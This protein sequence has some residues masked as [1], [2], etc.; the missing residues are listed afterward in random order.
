MLKILLSITILISISWGDNRYRPTRDFGFSPSNH[1]ANILASELKIHITDNYLEVEEEVVLE[2]TMSSSFEGDDYSVELF[3]DFQLPKGSIIRSSILWFG[4]DILKGKL[5]DMRVARELYEDVVQRDEVIIVPRDPSLI[6][7]SSINS[8]SYNYSI[9]PVELGGTRRMRIRYDVPIQ[10]SDTLKVAEFASIFNHRQS[11]DLGVNLNISSEITQPIKLKTSNQIFTVTPDS[12]YIIERSNLIWW[13]GSARFLIEDTISQ[14]MRTHHVIKGPL[15]GYYH[16]VVIPVSDSLKTLIDSN[17]VNVTCQLKVMNS[18]ATQIV[19]VDKYYLEHNKTLRLFIRTESEWEGSFEWTVFDEVG[20]LKGSVDVELDSNE[21]S[22][23]SVVHMWANH[24]EQKLGHIL[25]YVDEN[26]SLLALEKDT[27]PDS[28]TQQYWDE[29]VPLLKSYEIYSSIDEIVDFGKVNVVVMD[30][31]VLID[32]V[33]NV[34]LIG[35]PIEQFLQWELQ[36]NTL[37]VTLNGE[38]LIGSKVA[39]Y[40]LQGQLLKAESL[41]AGGNQFQLPQLSRPQYIVVIEHSQK[42]YTVSF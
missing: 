4:E 27:L 38:F 35:S 33:G 14:S 30:S 21:V 9:Y 39:A 29:G 6:E 1:P 8:N 16:E 12:D 24:Q 2:A 15:E 26:M 34:G 42:R 5:M 3:G 11:K 10:K 32:D 28:L 7:R 41:K 20:D 13:T 40:N 31:E 23:R 37:M 19:D 25:G 17:K 18:S 22:D 36:D